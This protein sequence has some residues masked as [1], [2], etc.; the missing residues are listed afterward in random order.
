MALAATL[1]FTCIFSAA[2]ESVISEQPV[3]VGYF[4]SWGIHKR[5]F[6]KNLVSDG[7]MRMLDQINY[8]QGHIQDNQCV[9]A[10]ASADL[11]YLFSPED[12][13]DDTADFAEMPLKGNFHQLQE[14]K[15][16]YPRIKIVISL[17]GNPE[18]FAEAAQPANVFAFVASCIQT[19]IEGNFADGVEAPGLFDGIDIDW[20]YPREVDKFNFLALLA[21]FRRQLDA[22]RPGLL[23]SVAMGDFGASYQHLDMETVALYADQIGVMNYDYSGPWSERTGLVA[24]LYSSMGAPEKSN[25]VDH[26]IRGYEKAGVPD[27]KILMGLP[28]YAYSWS[29]VWPDNHGLF[30]FGKPS[31]TDIPYNYIP[32]IR[33]A[34]TQYRDP[35]SMAPWLFDGVTFWTY[36]DEIS[37]GAKL[38]Y[39]KQQGLGGVMIWEL[40]GDTSDGKLLQTIS[41]QFRNP[42]RA[43][44]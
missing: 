36:D 33:S 5:F 23:L 27:S 28:F 38:E 37:I 11:N 8:S 39:A 40:S 14:L 22:A 19:F 31:H 44:P 41:E 1:M 25:D 4:P 18:A 35:N 7:A 6:V 15:R 21:E 9:I 24:P 32:S 16:L 10:D 42:K 13:I 43:T 34:F 17:E 3:V 20:E 12:S 2:Q 30:Q 26:T 29:N